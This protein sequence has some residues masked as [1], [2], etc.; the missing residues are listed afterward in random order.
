MNVQAT[1]REFLIVTAA[2]V[3]GGCANSPTAPT[4]AKPT[5]PLLTLLRRD[6]HVV[7]EQKNLDGGVSL[8]IDGKLQK[9]KV[10]AAL[11]GIDQSMGMDPAKS[12]P[13]KFNV[14]AYEVPESLG[15]VLV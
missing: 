14:A 7:V 9:I 12:G 1:R 11:I 2:M 13:P 15:Y 4:S 6:G 8:L 10:G 5:T 3:T